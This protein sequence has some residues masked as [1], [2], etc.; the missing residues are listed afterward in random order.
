LRIW[1]KGGET[2]AAPLNQKFFGPRRARAFFQKTAT[3]LL[4]LP[5]FGDPIVLARPALST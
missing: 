5:G 3:F 4:T 2:S 1:A